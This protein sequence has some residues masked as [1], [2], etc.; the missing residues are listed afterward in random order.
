MDG[1]VINIPGMGEGYYCLFTYY[2]LFR[3]SPTV[4]PRLAS[5]SSSCLLGF[6]ELP[7]YQSYWCHLKQKE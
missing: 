7:L 5:N 3:P 1:E 4:K 6:L 2:L